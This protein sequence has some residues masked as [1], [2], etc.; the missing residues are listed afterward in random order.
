VLVRRCC[1]CFGLFRDR[2]GAKREQLLTRVPGLAD[3]GN[4][5]SRGL[6]PPNHRAGKAR[7]MSTRRRHEPGGVLAE[8]QV[9]VRRCDKR[10]SPRVARPIHCRSRPRS[11]SPPGV[12]RRAWPRSVRAPCGSAA[13]SARPLGPEPDLGFTSRGRRCQYDPWSAS[14]HCSVDRGFTLVGQR[15]PPRQAG[16]QPL[17]PTYALSRGRGPAAGASAAG[18]C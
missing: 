11:R 5:A 2:V 15:M 16:G 6:R 17:R 14:P 3:P 1:S 13:P 7:R 4:V 8:G 9:R 10:T 12:E 18:G